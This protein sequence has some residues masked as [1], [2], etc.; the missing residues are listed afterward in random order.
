MEFL[1]N[2]S[3]AAS[4]AAGAAGV[5]GYGGN[6]TQRRVWEC[7]GSE[8]WGASSSQMMPIAQET[9]VFEAYNE[10]STVGRRNGTPPTPPWTPPH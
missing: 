1:S 3:E 6:D 7:L 4:Y 10:A 5:A 8:R 9:Y 2:L